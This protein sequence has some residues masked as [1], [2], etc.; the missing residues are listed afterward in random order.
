MRISALP[1][2]FTVHGHDTGA[3]EEGFGPPKFSQPNPGKFPLTITRKTT[4]GKLQLKQVW[5]K[6][7]A[8][9]KDVTVT[10]TIK[11]FSNATNF[12]MVLSRSGDFDVGASSSDHGGRTGDSVWQLD[13]VSSAAAETS[14]VGTMLTALTLGT[15][16]ETLIEHSDEWVGVTREVCAPGTGLP[17]PTSVQDVAMRLSYNFVTLN[18]GRSKTLKF[19]YGRM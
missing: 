7:D 12:D 18:A 2:S 8:T 16:D 14:R 15:N 9:E 6:P 1:S 4:D 17:T 19:E 5:S 13:D 10:M 11:N 3:V